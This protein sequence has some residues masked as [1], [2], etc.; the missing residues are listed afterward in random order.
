MA[1]RGREAKQ[2]GITLKDE[3]RSFPGAVLDLM[4]RSFRTVWRARGGGL[5]ACG[6][7]ITFVFLEVRML[8]TDIFQAESVGSFFTEQLAEMFFR[9]L[10]ES[11]RNTVAAFIWPV[12]FIEFQQPWG[13]GLLV[14]MYVV[15]AN[16]IKQPL[17][18]WLFDGEPNES[19]V[20]QQR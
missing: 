2:L 7:V 14:G 19:A 11:I 17:E 5:Y 3:P 12:W 4:R 10:G 1:E 20:D 8:F 9:Y 16:F 18:Q 15:F 6:F 13:I